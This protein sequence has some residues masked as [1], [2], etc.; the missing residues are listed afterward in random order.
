MPE[1]VCSNQY[2]RYKGP[3]REIQHGSFW[4]GA[5]LCLLFVVPGVLYFI[6]CRR[7]EWVCPHCGEKIQQDSA[8]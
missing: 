1:I 7:V 8:D 4:L 3:P 6:F 5:L 2:C